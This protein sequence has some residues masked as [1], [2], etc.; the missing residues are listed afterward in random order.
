MCAWV[1]GAPPEEV[2]E[3]LSAHNHGM[4]HVSLGRRQAVTFKYGRFAAPFYVG[5]VMCATL[6]MNNVLTLEMMIPAM[7]MRILGPF[8]RRYLRSTPFQNDTKYRL[9]WNRETS[10][11]MANKFI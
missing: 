11:F 5:S 1:K 8:S 3:V 6:Q 4:F 9:I 10:M 7:L 2:R